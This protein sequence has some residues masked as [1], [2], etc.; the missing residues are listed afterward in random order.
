[1]IE[2][3]TTGAESEKTW[4]RQILPLGKRCQ[5]PRSVNAGLLG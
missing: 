5:S 1:M 3:L 4:F 2:K